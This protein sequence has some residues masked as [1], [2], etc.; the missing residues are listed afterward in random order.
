M[1]SRRLAGIAVVFGMLAVPG[2][3]VATRY[4]TPTGNSTN[5]CQSVATG[6][7]LK[8]AIEGV[9]SNLPASGEEVIVEPGSYSVAAQIS[10]GAPNLSIHGVLG[11]PRP[12]INQSAPAG[13]LNGLS[14]RLSYLDFEAGGTTF[15]NEGGG[16]IDRVI[17]RGTGNGNFTCQCYGGT[18]RDSVFISDGSTAAL[19]VTSNGGSS[20]LTLRN[21]TAI[22]T[23]SLGTA[24]TVSHQ[25]MTGT[26]IWDAY[27]VIARSLAGG[28][29]VEAIGTNMPTITFHRS[30][31]E[32]TDQGG[33]TGL[34]QDAPGDA[35][36]SAAPIFTNAAAGDFSEATGSPTIDAGITDALN[37]PLDFAGNPRSAG[38]GT[39]IGA[40]EVVVP[41][42]SPPAPSTPTVTK[43]KC[44]KHKKHKKHKKRFASA[45]KKKCKKKK[46][47]K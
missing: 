11:Q 43:K 10:E 12:V 39:D 19:G 42:S 31:Y 34:V 38:G 13:Q 27:N 15:V 24:I 3:A 30:N 26:I 5:D 21:V 45:A 9:V 35:H 36:Q 25:G 16:L 33:G 37:G 6:C 40:Y 29:D 1:L 18:I 14:S 41:P 32:T 47:K 23:N 4:V 8:T 46:H 2:Q 44:K 28:T 22:T 7:D 20:A 17:M